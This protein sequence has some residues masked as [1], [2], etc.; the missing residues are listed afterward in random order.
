MM[1]TIEVSIV[2]L[3]LAVAFISATFF[4]VLPSP[5]Q[6]SSLSLG[7]LAFTTLQVLDTGQALAETVF[8]NSSDPSWTDFEIA[9]SACLPPNIVYNLTVYDLI[10][11][12]NTLTYSKFHSITNSEGGLGTDSEA[13]SYLVT[14]TN[15]TFT[16]TPEKISGTLYI[17]NCSDANGWWITGYTSQ[18]LAGDLY[19]LLSPYF[20]TTI[21]VQNTTDFGYL[22]DG[23]KISNFPHENVTNAIILN[24]FGEAVPIPSSY[25]EYSEDSFAEYCYALGQRVNQYNWTLVSIVGYP[26]YYVSNTVELVSSQNLW[27][28]YGMK[29]VGPRGLSAF[30]QGLANKAYNPSSDSIHGPFF[31]ANLNTWATY[32][33]NYYGIYPSPYQSS[34]R[35]LP[36]WILEEYDLTIDAEYGY[37]FQQSG[38]WIAG[39]TYSH[40]GAD[41]KIHGAFTALGLTRTPDV[42]VTALA[43]LMYYRP[44][45]YKSEF[46]LT[47]GERPTQRL[48]VLQ[49]SQ[50]GGS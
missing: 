25:M 19:D 7:Q 35:S 26:L 12:G 38:E 24:T 11:T 32:Y 39:A 23:T 17:L 47:A 43:L 4:A 36:D 49:L 48:I 34:T 29:D 45:L 44:T 13:S 8:K 22:L 16:V 14:S 30:L 10:Q 5:R 2:I 40:V 33:S 28:I 46:T 3:I 18:S 1:R 6:V 9:L 41:E 21:M 31:V 20:N 42:R 15:V 37:V 50:Q 27:G